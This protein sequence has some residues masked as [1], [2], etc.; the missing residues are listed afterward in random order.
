[1]HALGWLQASVRQAKL[2]LQGVYLHRCGR[3][4]IIRREGWHARPAGLGHMHPKCRAHLLQLWLW[5]PWPPSC[6][7]WACVLLAGCIVLCW[8]A[9]ACRLL[10]EDAELVGQA[11]VG[12]LHVYPACTAPSLLLLLPLLLLLL[13]PALCGVGLLLL[14]LLLLALVWGVGQAPIEGGLS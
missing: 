7:N 9:V 3:R 11:A 12:D 4:G 10:G 5:L 2:L 14:L 13:L 6:A 1:M 8:Q